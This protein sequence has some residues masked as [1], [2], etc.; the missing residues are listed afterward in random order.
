ML[1]ISKYPQYLNTKEDYEFI[2]NNFE[3]KYWLRDYQ[4]LLSDAYVD[5]PIG[6]FVAISRIEPDKTVTYLGVHKDN[7][8]DPSNVKNQEH[9][10]QLYHL[11]KESSDYETVPSDGDHTSGDYRVYMYE[12][13]KYYI[14]T[15]PILNPK[16]KLSK[17]GY[18][19]DEVMDIIFAEEEK[20][21]HEKVDQMEKEQMNHIAE[22]SGLSLDELNEMIT[23]VDK[24]IQEQD[25]IAKDTAKSKTE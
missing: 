4:S 24:E 21:A 22:E 19:V 5:V 11:M 16:S 14:V 7:I 8:L 15:K 20:E 10:K 23:D 2:R 17:I 1:D 12:D 6:E 25:V 13:Q 9:L 3:R 18:T